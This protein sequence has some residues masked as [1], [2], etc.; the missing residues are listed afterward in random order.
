MVQISNNG[1]W[2]GKNVSTQHVYDDKLFKSLLN[3]FVKQQV[4]SVADLGCGMGKYVN[5]FIKNGIKTRGFDGNPNTPELSNGTCEVLDLSKKVIFDEPFSWILSLEVGEHLPKKFEDTFINNLHFNN[6]NGII[7]SW[8]IKG[9]PGD[10]HINCQ[11]ND[12]IK[13][14]ICKLGYIND[15]KLEKK[16]RKRAKI[17]WFKKTIMVFRKI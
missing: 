13:N 15:I 16:F 6:K 2:I 9:Q 12:Y 7:L 14:K 11:N 17:R 10:G 4:T 1:F 5:N 3:F 8:A